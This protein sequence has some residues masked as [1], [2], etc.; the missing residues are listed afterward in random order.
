MRLRDL[1]ARFIV[2]TENGSRFVASIDD[3]QGL[4]YQCPTC[5]AGKERG[6]SSHCSRCQSDA[7][8]C[9]CPAPPTLETVGHYKGAHYIQSWF[10][11]PRRLPSVPSD[12][13]PGPGR[14][15]IEGTSIDDLTF[16]HGE[17]S[18]PRSVLLQGPGCGA[19]FCVTSG[20]I[21]GC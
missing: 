21:T 3:A 19:H 12:V 2:K 14:W 16:A 1:D 20:A 17:P 18:M 11:N 10:R 15:W 13:T 7:E 5:A 4:A 6:E 9:E 8:A